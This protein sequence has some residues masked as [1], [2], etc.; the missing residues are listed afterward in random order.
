MLTLSH[1]SLLLY[2]WF[3]MLKEAPFWWRGFGFGY[4]MSSSLLQPMMRSQRVQTFSLPCGCV[5]NLFRFFLFFLDIFVAEFWI[6]PALNL[7]LSCCCY[8][9][10]WKLELKKLYVTWNWW[11]LVVDSGFWAVWC[12]KVYRTQACTI[13]L[14]KRTYLILSFSFVFIFLTML[15]ICALIGSC[16][17]ITKPF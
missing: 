15:L 12:K 3:S 10:E 1:S 7:L 17:H 4:L 16:R 6:M 13:W 5:I 11:C 2:G 8:K 9:W 14:V